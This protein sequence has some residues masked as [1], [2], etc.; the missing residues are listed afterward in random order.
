MRILLIVEGAPAGAFERF[1]LRSDTKGKLM[2]GGNLMRLLDSRGTSANRQRA[3][4][5][6]HQ[7]LEIAKKTNYCSAE[8]D[9]IEIDRL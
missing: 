7:Q 4:K 6:L 3:T 8:Y 2:I 9:E 5:T 1:W